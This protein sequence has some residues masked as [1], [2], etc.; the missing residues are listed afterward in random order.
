MF[1]M[2]ISKVTIKHAYMREDDIAK[3]NAGIRVVLSVYL[4]KDSLTLLSG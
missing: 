3:V 2:S 4:C 1:W